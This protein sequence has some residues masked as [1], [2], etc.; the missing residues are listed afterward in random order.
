[1][2]LP[3]L[4]SMGELLLAEDVGQIVNPSG[5]SVDEHTASRGVDFRSIVVLFSEFN[6]D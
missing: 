3:W 4:V 6:S 2:G 1:M 5:S